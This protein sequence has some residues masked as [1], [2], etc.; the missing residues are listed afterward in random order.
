MALVAANQFQ[1][2][3]DVG[4]ALQTG[5]AI[6]QQFQQGQETRRASSLRQ[7]AGQFATQA[8]A[9]DKEAL[10]KLAGIDVGRATQ[11]REFLGSKSEAERSEITR[12][13]ESLTRTA[14]IAQTLPPQNMRAFIERQRDVARSEGR[15]TTRMDR[16]LSGNDDQ[17]FEAIKMQAVEGQKISDIAKRLFPTPT[18][19]QRNVQAAGFTPGTPE[20]EAEVLRGVTKPATQITIGGEKKEAEKLAELRVKQLGTFQEEREAAIDANQSLDVLDNIDVNTGTLEPAKQGLAAFGKAFGIDT[21]RLANVSAGEAFNAEAQR[22]VLA[23]KASQKGPQT[24]KDEATIRQTVANLGN[25]KEGNQ[26]IIDSARA[27]NIRKIDRA[28][29]FDKLLED[30]GSLKGANRDW[31]KFKRNTPMVSSN[32]RTPEGLPVFFFKFEQDVRAANPDATR[33]EILEAWREADKRRK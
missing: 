26:F 28:D 23:V 22:I 2:V 16:A 10:A 19:L 5:S 9:G 31:A 11:I 32:L 27:L 3:P 15:D 17:L 30:T 24:D 13:N 4:R 25:T 18:T 6:G 29:F 1:L 33:G 8:A 12:E 20:F 7:E 21:S 14:L